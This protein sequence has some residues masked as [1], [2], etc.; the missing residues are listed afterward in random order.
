MSGI[1][2]HIPF[3]KQACNYC[4]FHFSTNLDTRF[5]IIKALIKEISHR[6]NY[7]KN[8]KLNSIYFGG[9][10]PSLLNINELD[11]LFD[12][13]YR[14]FEFDNLTEIT[15]EVNP[16][17]VSKKK[18]DAWKKI[19]IN[20]LSIGI[21]SFNDEELKWMNRAHEAEQSIN[22]ILLA[23]DAGFN[24]ITIDLIYGSKFQTLDSWQK[25]LQ[26]AV[27]LKTQHISSYNL[28]IE[29]KTV[30]GSR[31]AKGIEPAVNENLSSKQFL[32]MVDLL[33]QS[34]F[35]QYEVSNFGKNGFFAQHNSNYW[36]QKE[37]LGIGPSAHSFDGLSRQWN[38]KNNN[39]Y[40]K[41]IEQSLIHFER[42]ELSIKD[43]FN[44]YV[45]TRLR[46]IWGCDV[47]EIEDL[48]GEAIK[49]HFLKLIDKQQFHFKNNNGI[50]TLK[51]ESL[52]FA[53]GIASDFFL[54]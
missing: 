29:N 8:K 39:A 47:N 41:A 38:I 17:D 35:I 13:L 14:Y 2:I 3:C 48:F 45:L 22:S 25:T 43:R 15:F 1:Y 11:L 54:E 33:K 46:T 49:S 23:Q 44:E 5:L 31:N 12:T 32:L 52:L 37:Y 4:D 27:D 42:E 36:L 34:D 30:L 51:G 6:S 9:G 10:T 20:R 26:K 24:N 53:D 40:I 19:G 50:Y 21:Q 18:L 28:T 16:D 7:L